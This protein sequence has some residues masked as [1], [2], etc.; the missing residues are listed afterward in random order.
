MSEQV[1]PSAVAKR[2]IFKFLTNKNVKRAEILM[3]LSAQFAD[4]T[5]SRTLAYDWRKSFKEGRR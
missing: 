1:V 3:R 5:L 2:V 4:V